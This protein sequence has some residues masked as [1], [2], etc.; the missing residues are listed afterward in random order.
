MRCARAGGHA[1]LFDQLRHLASLEEAQGR[2]DDFAGAREV[3]G[4]QARPDEVVLFLGDRNGDGSAHCHG[5]TVRGKDCPYKQH[6]GMLR[7][8]SSLPQRLS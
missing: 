3:T 1:W 7:R 8:R 6:T 5:V 2:P 4:V